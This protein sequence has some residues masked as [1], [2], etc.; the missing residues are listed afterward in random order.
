MFTVKIKTSGAAFRDDW[1][2]QVDASGNYPLDPTSC[3]IRRLLDRIAK[4]LKE[5]N[6]KGFVFDFNGNKVGEWKLE[7]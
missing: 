1:S 7:D 2:G 5:G 3:E 4:R 6:T